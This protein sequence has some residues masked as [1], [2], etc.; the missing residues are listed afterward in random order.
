MKRKIIITSDG[1][2]SIHIPEIEESYH[3]RKGAIQE[4]YYVYVDMGL[5]QIDKEE[6][7]VLEIGL[8]TG[9]NCFISF[10][11][12]ERKIDYVAVDAYPVTIEEA[13]KMNFVS[14][15][16]AEKYSAVFEK[17]HEVSWEEKHLMG[18][19]FFLTKRK[20]SFKDIADENAYDVIYFDAF[21]PD[22][23]P[24]L[25]TNT[26]FTNMYKALK[27]NG[28]LVTYSAKGEVRRTLMAVGFTVEKLDGPPGKRHML[29]GIK[30]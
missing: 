2:T 15:L 5:K 6:V 22:K 18:K 30:K 24:D 25:W 9:L 16:K 23:Q 26:I 3:S 1:S 12:E 17:I 7:S 28:V 27:E 13:G 4:A 11:S 14:E 29:R 21:G 20:Q 19:D 8:G 10:L